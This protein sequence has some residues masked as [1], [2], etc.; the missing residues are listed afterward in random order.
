MTGS[1]ATIHGG[2]VPGHPSTEIIEQLERLLVDARAGRIIGLAYA[3]AHEGG[4]QGTGWCGEAGSRH[5]LGTAV[6]MLS[7]RYAAGLLTC[8]V[9]D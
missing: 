1:V 8:Q 2:R 6:M 4:S 3:V 5:P 9:G 7:H